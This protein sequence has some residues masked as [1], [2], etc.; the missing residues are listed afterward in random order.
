M[1][2]AAPAPLAAYIVGRS[3]TWYSPR[4]AELPRERLADADILR[5]LEEISTEVTRRLDESD[6]PQKGNLATTRHMRPETAL[7]RHLRLHT[8]RARGQLDALRRLDEP[9]RCPACF[10]LASEPA[11]SIDIHNPKLCTHPFHTTP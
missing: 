5:R 3:Q 6:D 2:R 9:A 11:H 4:M 10:G 1:A 8:S 7:L